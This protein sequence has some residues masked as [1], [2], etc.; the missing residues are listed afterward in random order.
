MPRVLKTAGW[1]WQRHIRRQ[2][3][4]LLLFLLSLLLLFVFPQLHLDLPST[5]QRQLAAHHHSHTVTYSFFFN[6][7]PKP[8]SPQPYFYQSVPRE[9]T[10]T[11]PSLVQYYSLS[12]IRL[13]SQTGWIW[14]QTHTPLLMWQVSAF[15]FLI[16]LKEG[17]LSWPHKTSQLYLIR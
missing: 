1:I 8:S 15:I 3:D 16:G 5:W 13:N 2:P 7:S 17:E 4:D 9:H 6:A 12:N 10:H 14:H 11:P